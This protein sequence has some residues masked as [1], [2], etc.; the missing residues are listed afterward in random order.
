MFDLT[1]HAEKEI[2]NL[3]YLWD[4]KG[5]LN[6]EAIGFARKPLIECNLSGRFL[7]KKKWNNWVIFGEEVLFSV[8]VRHF[9]YIAICYVYFLEYE[10]QLHYEKTV[11]IPLGVGGKLKMPTRVLEPIHFSNSELMLSIMHHENQTFIKVASDHFDDEV[12]K[13]EL[14]ILHSTED[15]SLNVVVPWNRQTFHFTAKH[16]IL[17]TK[18]SIKLG[19]RQFE[20]NEVECFAVHDFGRG[21]WPRVTTWHWAFASQRIR[22][23]RIGINLG[24]QWTDGTGITENAIFVNGEMTK[25]HEDVLFKYDSSNLM[26]PWYITTKFSDQVMLTFHPFFERVTNT[27]VK[28]IKSKTRQFIGYFNG[29]VKLNDG[30]FVAI[31]QMLGSI[32]NYDAK[33]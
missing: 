21:V 25:I 26:K 19:N 6:P 2:V 4:K 14:V 13:A 23:K 17:P 15:E 18:G 28:V 30:S 5:N 11:T 10:T 31:Q 24:G 27:D 33:W 3:T 22:D 8:S 20:F 16:H 32:E 9:D 1:Q 12:L 7:R 29:R